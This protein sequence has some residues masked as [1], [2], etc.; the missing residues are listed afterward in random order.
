LSQAA[1]KCVPPA[2]LL[3]VIDRCRSFISQEIESLEPL[4]RL[5]HL[6]NCIRSLVALN[7]ATFSRDD[8]QISRI[9][10]LIYQKLELIARLR[11]DFGCYRKRQDT[12]VNGCVNH[13][14]PIAKYC[15]A[16]V[17]IH[18]RKEAVAA[19][20]PE[21]K[22]AV[23]RFCT[24]ELVPDLHNAED[25]NAV[26]VH[27]SGVKVGYLA[28]LRAPLCR[29]KNGPKRSTCDAVM[30]KNEWDFITI[31]LD[32]DL[33]NDRPGDIAVTF[34]DAIEMKSNAPFELDEMGE[35]RLAVSFQQEDF[36][37]MNDK[38]EGEFFAKEEWDTINFYIEHK[39]RCG[40]GFKVLAVP[41][42]RFEEAFGGLDY[43]FHPEVE[44]QRRGPFLW[45]VLRQQGDRPKQ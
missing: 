3:P 8:I 45:M 11:K 32:I 22:H 31:Y 7:R 1:A 39:K 20:F 33:E 28:R 5:E 41:K 18:H 26:G 37:Y 21:M 44:I 42:K 14:P 27:I 30:F 25:I 29:G 17:G 13:W 10:Y 43:S 15:E 4:R 2:D 16:V 6:E 23:T 12:S 38:L 36:E 9:D 34:A 35:I 40:P 24:A 19:L